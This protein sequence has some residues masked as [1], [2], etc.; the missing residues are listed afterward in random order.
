VTYVLI[1][2]N[3]WSVKVTIKLIQ[4]NA[5]SRSTDSTKNST[6]KNMPRFGTTKKTWLV[7][8]WTVTQY[9]CERLEDFFS[10]CSKEQFHYQYYTQSQLQFQHYLHPRTVLDNYQVYS[11]LRELWRHFFGRHSK[12]PKL[13]E[14]KAVDFIYSPFLFYFHSP[15]D[16]CFPFSILRV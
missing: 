11:Q 9:D 5:H 3:A 16:L 1:Y 4:M 8:P 15:F 6:L 12:L 7:Q 2:S 10:K 13:S 14:L